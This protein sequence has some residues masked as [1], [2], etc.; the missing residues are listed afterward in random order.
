MVTLLFFLKYLYRKNIILFSCITRLA[1]ILI[2]F[3]VL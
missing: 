2:N 1:D 3:W